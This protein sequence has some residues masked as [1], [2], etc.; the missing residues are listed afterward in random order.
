MSYTE[1]LQF[2]TELWTSYLAL[3]AWCMWTDTCNCL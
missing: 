3:S 2:W 1:H